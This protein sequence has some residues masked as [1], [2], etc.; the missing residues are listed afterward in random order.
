MAKKLR[1]DVVRREL[2]LLAWGAQGCEV[3]PDPDTEWPT[4]FQC[5]AP[6][7]LARFAGAVR[8]R[9]FQ[10]DAPET[11]L[12]DLCSGARHW[13]DFDTL[14]NQVVAERKR[15]DLVA[16]QK[17]AQQKAGDAGQ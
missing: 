7:D 13:Q 14:A 5:Y 8:E 10:E 4:L 1:F 16:A 17:A 2:Q 9:Y 11:S 3:V 12:F 6:E 15:L